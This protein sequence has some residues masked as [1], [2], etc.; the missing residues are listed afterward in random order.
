MIEHKF[1]KETIL[2]SELAKVIA[3]N[4]S[5]SYKEAKN[6]LDNV[7]SAILTCIQNGYGINIY[8]FGKFYYVESDAYIAR[9]CY[10]NKDVYIPKRRY[11][12]FKASKLLK[13]RMSEAIFGTENPDRKE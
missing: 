5:L 11:L 1:D 4:N 7:I 12:K 10:K 13:Y 2:G 3:Q 9:N 8:G 6:Q